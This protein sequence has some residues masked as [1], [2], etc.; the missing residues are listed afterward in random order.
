MANQI[1]RLTNGTTTVDFLASQ[2][3]LLEGG[4]SIPAPPLQSQYISNPYTDGDRLSSQRY[5]NRTISLQIK[6]V[7]T[8][9][10]DL[11]TQIRT[12][13]RL[14]TD[15]L[16]T[17]RFSV[18]GLLTASGKLFLETQFGVAASSSTFFEVVTAR[19]DM[20]RSFYSVLLSQNKMVLDAVL[21]LECKPFGFYTAQDIAQATIENADDGAGDNYQDITTSESYGDVPAGLY[22]K[23][24]QSVATGS[25]K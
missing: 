1:C 11:Q 9:L 7:G 15:A 17:S 3:K 23:I 4:L 22:I 14:I 24:D 20:P 2:T 10:A 21:S 6:I 13:E 19:L 18:Q 25:K 12:L 5:G 8:T 16:D